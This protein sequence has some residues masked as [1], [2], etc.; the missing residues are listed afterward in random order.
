MAFLNLRTI[1]EDAGCGLPWVVK[2]TC[3][4]A[5]PNGYSTLNEL[6]KLNDRAPLT[7]VPLL[8]PASTVC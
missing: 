1:L 7:L 5:D 6:F 2:V 4:V 8:L 3:F